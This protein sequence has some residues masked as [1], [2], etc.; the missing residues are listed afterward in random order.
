MFSVAIV[1]AGIGAQHADGFAALPD[2][3]R[4]HSVCDLDSARGAALADAHGARFTTDLD[5]V[6]A[7]PEVEIV[8]ICLPSHLHF[9]TAMLALE[10]GKHV[11]CEKPLAGSLAEVDQMV[12]K[13]EA[14]RRQVFPIFQYRFGLGTAQLA[15]VVEAGLAGTC[16][17]A[18]LETHWNRDAKYYD[19]DWRGTWAG[20]QGGALLTHAIHI[21]D[22]MTAL[23]GPVAEVSARLATRVNQIETED[24]AALTFTMESGAL[25]TSSVT[26]GGAQ[27]TSRLKLMFEGVTVESGLAP[28]A[29]AVAGWRFTARAPVRQADVDAALAQVTQTQSGYMAAF[30]E[31]AQ[32]LERLP[33]KAVTLADGRRSIELVTAIYQSSKTRMG[34]ALPLGSSHPLYHGWLP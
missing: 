10:A 34:E 9:S 24:C 30:H 8:D 25:V 20:E 12:A 26:L 14:A 11:I 5:S 33:H 16:Y 2:R 19:V 15:A 31:M 29:P 22:M 21:H 28:Y 17:A 27:D 4:I 6:L 13:A 32:A 1:G 18:T 3:F 23:L 7:D